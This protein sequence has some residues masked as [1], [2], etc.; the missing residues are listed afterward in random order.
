MWQKN[1]HCAKNARNDGEKNG[2]ATKIVV[3]WDCG[4]GGINSKMQYNSSAFSMSFKRIFVQFILI[5]KLLNNYC[6]FDEF[7]LRL[8]KKFS[9]VQGGN[10][11]VY[12]AYTFMTLILLLVLV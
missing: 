1:C 3:P 4:Y 7:S 2:C 6:K 10:V 8:A 12:L 9:R 5:Y 11:R